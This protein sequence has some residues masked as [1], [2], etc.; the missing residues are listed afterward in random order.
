MR[1]YR[2]RTLPRLN[3]GAGDAG[4]LP[5]RYDLH[6]VDPHVH[7]GGGG[8]IGFSSVSY[9]RDD[10]RDRVVDATAGAR[11]ET[12]RDGVRW[13]RRPGTRRR[14]TDGCPGAPC[15]AISQCHTGVVRRICAVRSI[16]GRRGALVTNA[17]NEESEVMVTARE[18]CSST[19]AELF[20]WRAACTV[21]RLDRSSGESSQVDG[22]SPS[23]EAIVRP[24]LWCTRPGRVT[25]DVPSSTRTGSADTTSRR[26]RSA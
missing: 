12:G 25:G 22:L 17:D 1:D 14:S 11:M 16:A 23:P 9:P 3:I 6:S 26:V 5:C 15:N 8:G 7:P 13:E 20:T 2:L 4:S 10:P 24:R 18:L 19:R 21:S